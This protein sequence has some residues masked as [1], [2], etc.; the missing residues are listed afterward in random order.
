MLSSLA[1]RVYNMLSISDCGGGNG[2]GCP[3]AL[4]G[5]G[6]V[7]GGNTGEEYVPQGHSHI[8]VIFI[9]FFHA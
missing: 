9:Y 8:H 1:P 3:V 7:N 2:G 5:P 4:L 6:H